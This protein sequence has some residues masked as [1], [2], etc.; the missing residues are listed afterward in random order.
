MN[1]KSNLQFNQLSILFFS[2]NTLKLWAVER[3]ELIMGQR[4]RKQGRK[5]SVSLL[6]VLLV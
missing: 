5:S 2:V 4:K 3:K 1:F 6:L